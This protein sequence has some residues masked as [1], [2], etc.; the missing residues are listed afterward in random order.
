MLRSGS[1]GID[2]VLAPDAAL[3]ELNR[4]F[5]MGEQGDHYFTIWYGVYEASTRTLRY[6]SA[7]APPAF[8]FVSDTDG[9]VSVA[10][11]STPAKPVGMFE[12]AEFTSQ[13]YVVPKGCR[14]LIYSDGAHEF[15]LADGRPFSWRDFKTVATRLAETGDLALAELVRELQAL[16]PTGAFEDD[17]SLVELTFD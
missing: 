6:A 17:C 8:A 14:I 1:L 7:G 2:T 5:Q 15:T 4:L 16:I 10:E 13:S 9:A 11:L 3:A 12:E